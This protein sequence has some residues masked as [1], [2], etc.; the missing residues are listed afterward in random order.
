M[1]ITAL[2]PEAS[3]GGAW[4]GMCCW[5]LPKCVGERME[6]IGPVWRL[7]EGCGCVE[8]CVRMCGVSTGRL[9]RS[10]RSASAIPCRYMS[11]TRCV[12]AVTPTFTLPLRPLLHSNPGEYRQSSDLGKPQL[13]C[14]SEQSASGPLH[15]HT[16]I[17]RSSNAGESSISVSDACFP[18]Q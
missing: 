13:N 18:F 6:A 2:P 4:G 12:R 3:V 15:L 17:A 14:K 8:L 9:T 11:V 1:A 10:Q 7:V 5:C 16:P